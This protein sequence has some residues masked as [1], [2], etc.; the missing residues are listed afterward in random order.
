MSDPR[1][2]IPSVESLLQDPALAPLLEGYGREPVTR[3]LRD[4]QQSVRE[5]VSDGDGAAAEGVA[6]SQSVAAAWYAERVR[7]ALERMDRP[8]LRGVINA[9]GV[10]L[11][12]NLGRAPLADAARE[13]IGEAAGYATL[14]YDL[15]A[16]QR[17]S[18]HGHCADLLQ[19]L[20]GA[21]AALVVTN[22][23]A[24]V[25]LALSTLAAGR[26]AVISRG[27]LVEIGGSFRVPEIMARSGARMH[28]VGATNRTHP[29]DYRAA[30]GPDTAA[31]LK[32]HRSNFSMS[33][34]TAEVTAGELAAI[35]EE[36]GV[37]LIHDL[38]SGAIVDLTEI[39]LPP[40][41]TARQALEHGAAVV[42]MSGDKLLGGPQAGIL[43]G[44]EELVGRMRR[45]PLARAVRPDKLILAALEATLRLY[46]SPDRALREIPV[47]RML[48]TPEGELE[49][50]A[51]SLCQRLRQRGVGCETRP[52]DSTVGG[53]A[54]PGVQLPST[55]V[56]L[57]RQGGEATSHADGGMDADADADGG[58][59]AEMLSRRLRAGSPPVVARVQDA[60]VWLDPRTVDPR[61]EDA[62]VEVVAQAATPAAG[63]S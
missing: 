48:S 29:D 3:L 35:A 58:L 41:P 51:E 36:V 54:Y 44:S 7:D 47:L 23:A 43:L 49:E 32:V 42:T 10:V 20:T 38:G 22:N 19:E 18:R 63:G 9:T 26:E 50:R 24:A 16:G 12:T 62:L 15:E 37:P 2:R 30:L 13:A 45:N 25:L 31:I 57:V 56:V 59:D 34:Y 11:H 8:S 1:R 40:E 53:G 4:V 28:E 6:A 21:P 17:G 5:D 60:A 33:G 52:C 46:R 27:E 39:G 61:Q 55:C 14:E